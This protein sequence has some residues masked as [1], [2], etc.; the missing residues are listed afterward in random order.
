MRASLT[1]LIAAER[2]LIF[3]YS[4]EASGLL[5]ASKRASY[6]ILPQSDGAQHG[7]VAQP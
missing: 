5:V 4:R 7:H 6:A 1:T 2:F 3:R